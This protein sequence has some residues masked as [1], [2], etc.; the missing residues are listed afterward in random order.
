[1]RRIDQRRQRGWRVSDIAEERVISFQL[2]CVD[3]NLF[4]LVSIQFIFWNSFG[5]IASA[6][7]GKSKQEYCQEKE[8][9]MTTL[10]LILCASNGL[11]TEGFLF[12]TAEYLR[13]YRSAGQRPKTRNVF[14]RK[15]NSAYTS[16]FILL[17]SNVSL[18]LSPFW[19]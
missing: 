2:V 19:L 4:D 10:F 14:R 8:K 5:N 9:N 18:F 16:H 13:T 1:M 12:P 17:T 7:V 15:R 6:I 3:P 11:G